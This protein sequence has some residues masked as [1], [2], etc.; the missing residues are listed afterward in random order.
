MEFDRESV[1]KALLK[2]DATDPELE[3]ALDN[4]HL[5]QLRIQQEENRHKE[6]MK[7]ALGNFFG[8]QSTA[9]TFGAVLTLIFGLI[10]ASICGYIAAFGSGD[11]LFWQQNI[12][13]SIAL[14][15]ACLAYLFGKGSSGS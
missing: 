15:L 6:K 13:R 7:G 2:K 8:S 11:P 10:A 12:E 4:A 1:K 9:A 3:Q 5:L 14:S